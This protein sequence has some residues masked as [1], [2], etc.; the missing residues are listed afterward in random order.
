MKEE[1]KKKKS[2]KFCFDLGGRRDCHFFALAYSTSITF[3]GKSEYSHTEFSIQVIDVQKQKKKRQESK[4]SPEE[5]AIQ[6][7]NDVD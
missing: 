4:C 2:W 7:Q 6:W 1:K 3:E 5:L